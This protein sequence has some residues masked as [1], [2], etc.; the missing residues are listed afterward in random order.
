MGDSITNLQMPGISA[1]S[2]FANSQLIRLD[3]ETIYG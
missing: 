3:T 2:L 1:F